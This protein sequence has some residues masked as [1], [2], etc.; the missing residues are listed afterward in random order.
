MKGTWLTPELE[1]KV[2][3]VFEPRYKRNLKDEEV[4]RIAENLAE[5]MEIYFKLRWKDKYEN[6]HI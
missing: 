3:K 2:R 4:M 1:I 5:V 6:R